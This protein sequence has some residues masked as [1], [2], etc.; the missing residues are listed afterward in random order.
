[1]ASG[2]MKSGQYPGHDE[3]TAPATVDSKTFISPAT[4]VPLADTAT[5]VNS[6]RPEGVKSK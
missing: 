1:M 4:Y 6:K 3:N 5:S 2:D